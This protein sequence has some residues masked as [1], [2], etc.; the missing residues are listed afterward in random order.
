MEGA[1]RELTE[2]SRR[3]GR[4]K[5]KGQGAAFPSRVEASHGAEY[6]RTV[7]AAL[8][9]IEAGRLHKVMVARALHVE[10]EEVFAVAALLAQLK[11]R[12][13]SCTLFSLQGRDG[14]QFVGATPERLCAIESGRLATEALAGTS[15]PDEAEELLHSEKDLREHKVVVDEIRRAVESFALDVRAPDRPGVK[16]LPNVAHLHTPIDV[17]LRPGV[18][19]A[20]LIRALHPTPSVGGAPKERAFSFLVESEPLERGWYA[21]PIGVF[22]PDRV[23][24]YVALRCALIHGRAARVYVGAG[25]VAGSTPAAELAETRLKATA[26]LS[27]LGAQEA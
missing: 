3:L 18:S 15:R 14:A 10:G 11:A 2:L 25:V 27:A 1:R 4:A 20:Q 21:G 26:L 7:A 6:Q 9:A 8:D 19:A 5:R 17:S 16:R 13:P 24:A 22:G 12:F 23:E